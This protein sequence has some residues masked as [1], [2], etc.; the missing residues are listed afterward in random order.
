M[1]KCNVA[2]KCKAEEGD[3]EDNEEVKEVWS[4]SRYG[5]R[6]GAHPWLEVHKLQN[7][8]DHEKHTEEGNYSMDE[9]HELQS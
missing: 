8:K 2:K 3:K 9:N 4:R 1:T 5:S 6:Y 7:A